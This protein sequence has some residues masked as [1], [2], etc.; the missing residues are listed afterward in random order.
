[1]QEKQNAD[2]V[3]PY[4]ARIEL[5]HFH[6]HNFLSS[7]VVDDLY[8]VSASKIFCC[9]VEWLLDLLLQNSTFF[10]IQMSFSVLGITVLNVIVLSSCRGK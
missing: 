2:P 4:L 3:S 6:L 9:N 10:R 8:Y 7:D 1:M 5:R